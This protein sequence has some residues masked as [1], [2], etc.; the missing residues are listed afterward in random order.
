MSVHYDPNPAKNWFVIPTY[1]KLTGTENIKFD[2][3][4]IR[5]IHSTTESETII[6]QTDTSSTSLGLHYYVLH[7]KA[8]CHIKH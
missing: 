4:S 6:Q 1:W 7:K 3:G 5:T 8:I 2:P